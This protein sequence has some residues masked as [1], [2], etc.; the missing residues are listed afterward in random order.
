[1]TEPDRRKRTSIASHA[2]AITIV[3]Q[4]LRAAS[5]RKCG[6]VRQSE[7]DALLAQL[8]KLHD[9]LKWLERNK[10]DFLAWREAKRHAENR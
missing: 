6:G 1:M 10:D 8:D 7:F 4:L 3:Q 2:A 9:L 5:P